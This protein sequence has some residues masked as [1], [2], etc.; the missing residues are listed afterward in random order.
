MATIRKNKNRWQAVIR[1]KY[2]PTVTKSFLLKSD[3]SRWAQDSELK[4]ERG[5]FESLDEA[6]KTK[7]RELLE[8]YVREVTPKKKGSVQETYKIKKLMRFK[9]AEYTLARLT[10]TKIA[11]FRDELLLNVKPATVNKYL[12][13]IQVSINHAKREWELHLPINPV[14]N[15]KRLR[16]PEP[17]TERVEQWEYQLLLKNAERSKLYCLGPMIIFAMETG[18]RRGEIMRL[19]ISDINFNKSTCILRDTKNGSD[20]NIGVPKKVL[21]LL[22]TLP[23]AIDG[24][25]FNTN[26]EQFKWYWNQLRR[27]TGYKKKFHL[28]RSEFATRCFE[29]NWD[30]SSVATQGGWKDWKV[31]RRYT[32]ISGEFLS[33]K[34]NG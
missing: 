22:K 28:F 33:K 12:G 20:R 8:R 9:I 15:I 17:S 10:P 31:L 29:N 7:L 30:I 16:E 27:W 5:V 13:L 24:R 6:N 18:A 21:D 34:L 19:K 25:L 4:I 1:K 3:A 14:E 11:K 2:H 32:K 26:S 23:V